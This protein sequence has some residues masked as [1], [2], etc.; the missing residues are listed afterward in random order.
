MII[1]NKYKIEY[2]DLK[3]YTSIDELL[4]NDKDF[5]VLLYESQPNSGHW[6]ALLKYDN[7]IELFDSYGNTDEARNLRIQGNVILRV[8]FFAS[9]QIQVVGVVQG[10]GHGLDEQARLAVQHGRVLHPATRNGQAVDMTTN[11][12]IT[13]QLA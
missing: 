8:T 13:F 10:L 1:R 5:A 4:P 11:I 6:T 3:N 2:K 12:T 7:D 9:G